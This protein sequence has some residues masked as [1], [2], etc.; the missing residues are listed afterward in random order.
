MRKEHLKLVSIIPV[1]LLVF[2]LTSRQALALPSNDNIQVLVDKQHT[3]V[4]NDYVPHDLTLPAV[5][6]AV[7]PDNPEAKLRAPAAQALSALFVAANQNGIDLLLSSG[8][9]SYADQSTLYAK[10]MSSVTLDAQNDVAPPGMSEHQTGLAADIILKSYVC[11]A[12]GCFAITRAADWLNHNAHEYGFIMR[13]PDYK[14]AST[15]YSY[16]PWHY[17]Y[18]G[19]PVATALYRTDKTLEEYYCLN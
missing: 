5:N 11:A 9:R 14:Q 19:V 7:Y 10:T 16:E 4:P 2:A 12:Q 6:L 1:V 15:G 18:V 3:L 17:R 13:Y 8:Y